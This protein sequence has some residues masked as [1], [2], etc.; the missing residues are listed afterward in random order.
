MA[1][2]KADPKALYSTHE[3]ELIIGDIV[4]PC[5]VLEDETR[6]LTTAGV[7]RAL[8]RSHGR[9][10]GGLAL[11]GDQLPGFL[12]GKAIKSYISDELATATTP[13]SPPTR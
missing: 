11:D 2:E 5:A 13:T 6:V 1:R 10:R 4:I 12:R 8:E 7:L 3:G 9:A